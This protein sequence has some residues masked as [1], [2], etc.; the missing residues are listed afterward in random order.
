MRV[1][2][3]GSVVLVF[4]FSN[5]CCAGQPGDRERARRNAARE[6]RAN[7]AR[8]YVNVRKSAESAYLNALASAVKWLCTQDA[9][10]EAAGVIDEI[11]TTDEKYLNLKDLEKLAG[12]I[13]QPKALDDAKR[14][15]L[16]SRIAS[17]RKT[18]SGSLMPLARTCYDAGLMAYAYDLVFDCLRSEPENAIAR[19]AV[20]QVKSGNE[21]VSRYTASQRQAGNVYCDEIGWVPGAQAARVKAGEWCENG[22]WMTLAEANKLHASL[23]NPWIIETENFVLKS[24][25]TRGQA[26][27]IAERLEATRELCFREYLEFFMRGS[28]NRGT[29]LLFNAPS[30]KKLVVNYYGRKSD[31]ESAIGAL[32]T[33]PDQK[34]LMLRSAGLYSLRQHA[35]FFYY[36]PN[37]GPFQIIVMQHEITHQILGEYACGAAGQ[38]WLS[39]GVAKVLEA[40]QFGDDGRLVNQTGYDHPDI[41]TT[42]SMLKSGKA[43]SASQMMNLSHEAFHSEPGRHANYV[44]SGALCRFLLDFKEGSYAADFLE[45][46]YDSYRGDHPNIAEYLNMEPAALDVAFKGYLEAFATKQTNAPKSEPVKVAAA[47]TP[48]KA[49]EAK[50]PSDSRNPFEDFDDTV[51]RP[52]P[53]KRQE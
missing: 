21:W 1:G 18:R 52:N 15:E 14:K 49:P 34:K 23:S 29:Q 27:L 17:A 39:E 43:P 24:T 35:S 7:V 50:S 3:W 25:A 36:D 48:N 41:M 42:A 11:R 47:D 12:G 28:R 16:D 40:A 10:A 53:F 8:S 20:G 13:T 19:V 6:N 44:V 31:F 33:S 26:L 38:T 32:G 51:E 37:F 2:L 5:L 9:Q 22:K 46:L 45:Y 4:L 30:D